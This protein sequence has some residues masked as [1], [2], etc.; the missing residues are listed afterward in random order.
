MGPIWIVGLQLVLLFVLT[1]PLGLLLL[2]V[3]ERLLGRKYALSTPERVLVAFYTAGCF[4]LVSGW[5]PLPFYDLGFVLGA[6]LIGIVGYGYLCVRDRGAGLRSAL[7]FIGAWPSWVLGALTVGLLIVELAGVRTLP[8]GNTLDGSSQ[9]LWIHLLLRNH[10]QALTLAPYAQAGVEYPQAVTVWM[11]QPV[12][13]FDWPIVRSPLYTPT[14]FL[15]LSV[16]GGFC[17]GDRWARLSPRIPAAPAGLVVA[18]TFALIAAYPGMLVGGTFD[19]SFG[20]PL[21]LLVLG[22]LPFAAQRVFRSWSDLFATALVIGV[23]TG[24]APMLGAYLVLLFGAVGLVVVLRKG[25]RLASW[26]VRWLALV[27]GSAL[28]LLRSIVTVLVWFSYPDHVLAAAGNPPYVT[29]AP[30]T[31][32]TL[33]SLIAEV[34]P[35]TPFKPKLSPFPLMST[36]LQILLGITLVILV[37]EVLVWKRPIL[38]QSALGFA[39]FMIAGT[40]VALIETVGLLVLYSIPVI[41]PAVVSVTYLQEASQTLFLFYT[42][43]AIL[44]AL[45][46]LSWLYDRLAAGPAPATPMRTVRIL[47]RRSSR[48]RNRE[49]HAHRA[50]T[51]V[52]V[53]VIGIPLGS[54]LFTASAVAPGY[55]T[56]QIRSVANVTA[57]DLDALR[58]AGSN[59]PACSTVLVAPA[60]VGQYLP[61]FAEV[62]VDFPGYPAPTNQ[63]YSLLVNDL[64]A[65]SYTNGTREMLLWLGITEVLVSGQNSVGFPAF[66]LGPLESSGDFS[67]LHSSGSV[68]ILEFLPYAN[69]SNCSA[70]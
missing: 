58:W 22:W 44:P 56:G 68:T 46:G 36:E 15:S 42:L 70:A 50:L 39:S 45:A 55:I 51:L 37:V 20:L 40:A 28:F 26:A 14:L 6:L 19:Y 33:P 29:A 59:L 65:G 38:R 24:I 5:I 54:G 16:L 48:G 7:R 49:V 31:T 27:F 41:G 62:R 2:R 35:F 57:A 60:S 66:R 30:P 1:L 3:G 12:L 9:S 8:I 17:L 67:V 63:S 32:L 21:F 13:L 25:M 10:T 23:V 34:D 64:S 53:L 47:S 4:F 69:V 43:L 18:A 52:A 11:S 61:E